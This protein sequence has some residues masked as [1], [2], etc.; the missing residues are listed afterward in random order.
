MPER[1]DFLNTE[2]KLEREDYT[3][4]PCPFCTEQY[5]KEPPVRRIPEDRVLGKLDEH[6]SRNDTA[7]AERHLNY[8]LEEARLGRDL[9]GE[10][11]L[12]NE[13]VGLYRKAGRTDE[14]LAEADR[15]MELV[16]AL[17]LENET[18]GATAFINRGTALKA[19]GRAEEAL[20][21]FARAQAIYEKVPGTDP[22]RLG[23][24]YNNYAL[25]L[26]DAGRFGEARALY[27]KAL[28]VMEKADGGEPERAVTWLNLADLETAE[29]GPEEAE[30]A[31]F[32][33][34]DRA[35]ELLDAPGLT[36]DG[37]YAFVCEKCAPVFSFYGRF[38]YAKEIAA[39]AAEIYGR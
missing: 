24:L 17:G 1:N 28:S 19:F 12:R 8:W 18:A 20:P 33:C 16:A 14:C 32:R 10:F 30:E 15:V 9:R 36:R 11:L 3:D 7:A 2:T 23:G 4:P 35:E 21:L 39:R 5:E 31:V 27:E 29:K 38:V 26:A 6:L 13:L 22:F 34:L 25:A 37:N